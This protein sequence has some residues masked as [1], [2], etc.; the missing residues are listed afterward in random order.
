MANPAAAAPK[1]SGRAEGSA[2]APFA[3]P[4]FALLWT[5]TVVSNVGT[6]MNDVGAGWLMASL[7]PTPLMVSLVQAA[8]TLPIFLFALPAGALADIVDRR[9]L[10]ILLNLLLGA[11]AGCFALLVFAGLTEVWLLLAFTFLMGTG[12]AFMA[13]AWQ[14][15][16]PK[17]VERPQLQAA[18]ALNSMGINVSRAIGPALAG[19]LIAAAGIA[20]PFALNAVSFLGIILALYV[21]KPPAEAPRTLP[22]ETMAGAM[23]TGI[24]YVFQS[25]PLTATL[26]RAVAFFLFASA[27]WAL[28]PLIAKQV[29]AGGPE[30]YGLLLACLGGGAVAGAVVLP[31]AKRALGPDRTVAAGTLGT[32]AALLVLAGVRSQPAAALACVL[33]G[34]SWIWVLSSLNVSAQ[35]ALPDWVRARGLSVFLTV[36][37]GSMTLGSVVWGQTATAIGIPGALALAAAGAVIGMAVTW[38]AKLNQGAALDLTPSMHW[39]EPVLQDEVDPDRGPVMVT[40]EYDVDPAD[41]E[42]FLAKLAAF[43]RTRRRDGAYEWGVLEDSEAP[44]RWVEYFLVD[45]WLDHLRQH[46][47]VTEADRAEQEALQAFHRGVEKPRVRHLI[48]PRAAPKGG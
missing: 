5:A 41:A 9:R 7:A 1:A 28:L 44:G 6:W 10:L 29:L 2:W 16:V 31:R 39:P 22:P 34:L 43:S 21:W 33:A 3:R 32:A 42:D 8:T 26:L 46:G 48:G 23:R 14:A 38:R 19:L 30:L 40:V 17:L 27:Y 11:L 15:I 4:A 25:G 47:R 36:F 37:F 13:P 20:T 18:I 24:R 45:S 35:T 12:T